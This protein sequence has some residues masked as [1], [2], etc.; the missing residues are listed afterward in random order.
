M[1]ADRGSFVNWA[2][3]VRSAPV[4]WRRPANEA[5]VVALMREAREGGRRVRVVGGGH[6]WSDVAAP[7]DLAVSLDDHAGLV[8]VEGGRATV[9]AGTRLKD[10]NVALAGHG[11]AMP[12]LGSIAEQSVAGAIATGTHGS[13]LE[14]G[15]LASLVESMRLVTAAGE[16]LELSGNDPR[17]DA[18]RVHLGAF[19]I[20]TEVT[21]RVTPAF[22]LTQTME[23]LPVGEVGPHLAVIGRSAEYVKVW[24]LPHTPEALVI[25]YERGPADGSRRSR[26]SLPRAERWFD[27]RV[28]H[29]VLLPRIYARQE[30]RPH[31]VPRVNRLMGRTLVKG[32]RTGPSTLL[33]STPMPAKHFETEAALPLAEAGRAWD[34]LRTL[35]D[36]QGHHVNFIMELRYV[37]GD[38]GW[39]SPAH[40][41]DVVQLGAYTGLARERDAFFGA[42][43]EAMRPLGARPHWGKMLDQTAA[44]LA[45]M[46][47]RFGDFLALREELDP[48][49][50]FTNA[51][52]TRVLGS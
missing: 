50:M 48:D 34:A 32:R 12:I 3:T 25:R 7:D 15:N 2:G 51:F 41:G 17:L 35:I 29:R 49:R 28:V 46:Y 4:E 27:E 6:S 26:G 18:T 19:G 36:E 21:L 23:R 9:R 1:Q 11:L 45:P 47:P 42:F 24:W 8:A 39:L 44:E 37:K 22:S 43:W 31:E 40:G 5:E 13:S 38:D 33:F 14:H 30:R 20:V 10:L 16:T 52:L